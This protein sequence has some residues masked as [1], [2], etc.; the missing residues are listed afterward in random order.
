MHGGM[1]RL[2]CGL[3][4]KLLVVQRSTELGK[5]RAG[6]TASIKMLSSYSSTRLSAWQCFH[7]VARSFSLSQHPSTSASQ[8]TGMSNLSPWCNQDSRHSAGIFTQHCAILGPKCQ[9]RTQRSPLITH[10]S[11]FVLC[12]CACH[13]PTSA[14]ASAPQRV[15]LQEPVIATHISQP[16]L[17][18]L[19]PRPFPWLKRKSFRDTRLRKNRRLRNALHQASRRTLLE[20]R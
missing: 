14:G 1:Y 9:T 12:R 5:R 6:V 15:Q 4:L 18:S 16:S 11:A 20:R 3:D 19:R 17:L 13:F 10:G 7:V 2:P 8:K